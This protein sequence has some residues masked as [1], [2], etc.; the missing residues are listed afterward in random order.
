MSKRCSPICQFESFNDA[1][2]ENCS[3]L[4]F[5][6]PM[7]IIEIITSSLLLADMLSIKRTNR[8]AW[9]QIDGPIVARTAKISKKRKWIS[10]PLERFYSNAWDLNAFEKPWS[11]NTEY[12]VI[13][14]L[15]NLMRQGHQPNRTMLENAV[16]LQHFKIICW[17]RSAGVRF[18]SSGAERWFFRSFLGNC[19][20]FGC[21]LPSKK[22]LEF[23]TQYSRAAPDVRFWTQHVDR[24]CF[25]ADLNSFPTYMRENHPNSIVQKPFTLKIIL[26]FLE[27]RP[28]SWPEMYRLYASEIRSFDQNIGGLVAAL[29]DGHT[30]TEHLQNYIAGAASYTS[31][32][33]ANE[34]KSPIFL[35]LIEFFSETLK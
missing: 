32:A 4:P 35:K 28:K 6:V 15:G 30:I 21:D 22:A 26:R 11:V 10:N 34:T 29:T 9:S 20:I 2:E 13:S 14:V 31:I 8:A 33:L 5:D 18:E 12:Q 1:T 3:Q 23:L 19:D 27:H 16:S 17:L 24:Y 25:T 7:E